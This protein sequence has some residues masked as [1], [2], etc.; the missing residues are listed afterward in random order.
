VDVAWG[1]GFILIALTSLIF[2]A[3]TSSIALLRPRQLILTLMVVVWGLR[4]AGRIYERN[5]G[6]GE[7]FRYKA[8]RESWGRFFS[9]RAYFQI[10]MLQGFLLLLISAPVLLVNSY[11]ISFS[12]YRPLDSLDYLGVLIW[13]VGFYFEV[14]GDAQLDK[15]LAQPQRPAILKTGL[16][17]YTRHPN[18][19]GEVLMWWGIFLIAFASHPEAWITI[20]S[21]LMITILILFVSGV[22]MLERAMKKRPGYKEYMEETSVFL[23]WFPRKRR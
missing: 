5:L 1:L 12:V 11:S 17:R 4:L 6:K 10:Y 7:D 14:I 20:I 2:L 8:W 18:Y 21:P 22:P 23:P 15:Y 13:I 9:L 16:W 3:Q 19:F